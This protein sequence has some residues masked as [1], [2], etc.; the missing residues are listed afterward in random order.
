LPVHRLQTTKNISY[1]GF[2]A[3]FFLWQKAVNLVPV[4]GLILVPI[5]GFLLRTTSHFVMQLG[6]GLLLSTFVLYFLQDLLKRRIRLDDNYIFFGFKAVPIKTISTIDIIYGKNKFLP[7]NLAI[8]GLSGQRLTLSLSGL[9]EQS[10]ETLVRHLQARN[11]N[12]KTTAVLSTLVK[13]RQTKQKPLDTGEVLEL[14]YQARQSISES[15]DV[16]KS[17]AQKWMRVGP[18]LAC[19]LLAP[20]WICL[21]ATLYLGANHTSWDPMQSLN[22]FQFLQNLGVGAGVLLVSA[23]APVTLLAVAS[24]Q[25]LGKNELVTLLTTA[26]FIVGVFLYTQRLLWRPN[27][28]I[29]D[30]KGLKLAMRLGE[31]SLPIAGVPWSHVVRASLHSTSGKS[32]KIRIA[33]RDGKEFDLD[34]SAITPSNRGLLLKRIEKLVP[35]CQI[36]PDLSQS[37]LPGSEQ[38]YTELWL[39][40]LNLTPE[41]KTLEPLEPGQVV[42]DNRFEILRS[43]GVGGQGTAYLCRFVDS[44]EA[45]TVV[46]KETIIPIFADS[47]VRRKALERFEKEAKLLK[48]LKYDGIV[49][50][51][52]YFVE[53]HRAYLVLEH[54]DGSTLRELIQR[55]GPLTEDQVKDIALQM[56]DIL[57]FLHTHSVVHRDFTPENLILNSKGRLKLI[58]F[59]VAHQVQSGATGTIVGK[60]AYLPPEQ[61]RGKATTQSDLYALGATLFFLLTGSDPEPISQSSPIAKTSQISAHLDQ[62]VRHATTLQLNKRYQTAGEIASEILSSEDKGTILIAATKEGETLSTNV[63]EKA[64]VSEHG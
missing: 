41:R 28:L 27:I 14:P 59:N 21:L 43:L 23:L 10:I 52:D 13:C 47:A 42:G 9:S 3:Q 22:L 8:I 35:S 46:L 31:V 53:D 2:I 51:L 36:D 62:I 38:S 29:A 6:Y 56:C 44:T 30:T 1:G 61:F 18:L 39:Q 26:G 50:L 12:L 49:S 63:R 34:L 37:M 15:I 54:I 11:S 57:T 5:T 7:A 17:T 24:A 55:D 40:S 33:K 25:L 4:W 58:D 64:E 32:G 16:F 19:V 60:H 20:M 48:S 45:K